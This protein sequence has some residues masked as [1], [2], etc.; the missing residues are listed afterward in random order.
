MKLSGGD[1]NKMRVF[2]EVLLRYIAKLKKPQITDASF[3]K[4]DSNISVAMLTY[5]TLKELGGNY[6]HITQSVVTHYFE[7]ARANP[8]YISNIMFQVTVFHVMRNN[9]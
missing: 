6:L 7:V 5:A 3:S 9:L 2:V 8:N 1:S 4:Y